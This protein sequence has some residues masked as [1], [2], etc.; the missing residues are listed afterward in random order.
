MVS[1]SYQQQPDSGMNPWLV[2]LPILFISGV[3]L[4]VAVL[5]ALVAGF[6]VRFA[7]EIVPGMSSYGVNLSGMTH[8]EAVQALSSAFTYGDK[9][10]FTFRYNDKFWQYTA[11]DL[12]IG[13]DA[14]STVNQALAAGHGGSILNDIGAQASIWLNGRSI[15]PIV[16]YD[17]NITLTKLAEIAAQINRP[18]VDA[19]INLNGTLV[20]T[21]P[22]QTGLELNV[23]GTLSRLQEAIMQLNTGAEIGLVVSEAPPRIK[24]ADAAAAK[25]QLALSGPVTLVTD[26]QK[27]GTLGPWTATVDQIRA[28][29]AL[30]LVPNPDGSESYDVDVNTEAFRPFVQ[31]LGPGLISLPQ[32]GR[33][34]FNDQTHQLEPIADSVPGRSLDVDATLAA[35]HDGILS[36]T[37]RVVPLAFTYKLP[38]YNENVTATE[39]GI[40]QEVAEATTYYVGSTQSRV[41]NIIEAISRFDGLIIAPGEEFSFNYYLGDIS[42]EQ[43][44]VQGK[45]IFGGR[46]IDGVGGGVCQVSTTMFRA[47]LSAGFPIVERNTHGYRVGFYEQNGEPPGLDAAI[48]QPDADFRF[49]N[50]TPYHLL[51]E[52]S[53]FPSTQSIQFRFYSTNPG[54]QVVLEGPIIKNVVPALPTVYEANANLQLGQEQYVDWSAQGADVTFTRKILDSSGNQIR[55]DTIYSHYLPWAAVVQVAPSDPRLSNPGA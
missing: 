11:K 24:D 32:N 34:H 40:T 26:D 25:I 48:F 36:Q 9:A 3:V 29:L 31:S 19:T 30:K 7:D 21:T 38:D 18:P 8:D 51:I 52:T 1:A 12:G 42:P 41:Q 4:I 27:G 16:K 54:R 15:A 55:E 45:I 28:L 46:T 13:F 23:S 39:L 47:A 49:L 2:R 10:V 44:F 22:S 20:S 53:V 37:N 14:D 33:F 43:G 35:L 17:Q 6:E 5:V 50:D